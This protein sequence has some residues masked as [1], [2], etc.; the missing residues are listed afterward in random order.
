MPEDLYSINLN[1]KLPAIV[2]DS[3]VSRTLWT[4]ERVKAVLF[5]FAPGQELSEHTASTPAMNVVATAPIPGK[6]MP[7]RPWAG[8]IAL[9]SLMSNQFPCWERTLFQRHA[10]SVTPDPDDALERGQIGQNGEE[11][12]HD[13]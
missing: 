1:D 3:I 8:L 9:R 7:S 5:G 13:F 10:A 12:N 11:E 2:A 6:R 4:A